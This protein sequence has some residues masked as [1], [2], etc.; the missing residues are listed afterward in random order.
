MKIAI[1]DAMAANP[2]DLSWAELEE[3]GEVT[4]YDVTK[5][6]ELYER[7][8]DC[9]ICITNKTVF[10]RRMIESLPRLRYIG[11]LATGY[12]VVDLECCKEKGIV[13]TNVPEYSTYATA[14]MTIALILELADKV[15]IHNQSVKSGDWV[16][17]PQFCYWK[18]PLTELWNKTAVVVGYGKIGRRVA[19]VLSALGMQVIAVPHRF[20]SVT[21]PSDGNIRFMRLEEALPKADLVTLH[22]PL[23][24]ETRG[25]INKETLSKMKDGAFLINAARG[26][27]IAAE[28]V[29]EALRS[30]RLG[31]YA[32]D[33]L[34]VEPQ[35]EDDPFLTTPNTILTPHIAWAPKETRARL[36]TIAADNIRAFLAGDP[37]NVVN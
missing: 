1:L 16:R 25:I 30:G 12:N 6:E 37:I 9:E 8:K 10:D 21:D 27:L 34:E 4:A 13:V 3:F 17:S 24:E 14:Q 2:G 5:P 18:E 28:D 15:G 23:T 29:A 32:A 19:S 26:P 7:A 33:V 36:I 11:V 20:N 35:R 22:C 31:G